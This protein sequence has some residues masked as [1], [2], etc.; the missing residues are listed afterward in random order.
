MFMS[1]I[2]L[3]FVPPQLKKIHFDLF[4]R[5]IVSVCCKRCHNCYF[6]MHHTFKGFK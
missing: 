2:L 1:K 5:S 6:C 4:S 3:E